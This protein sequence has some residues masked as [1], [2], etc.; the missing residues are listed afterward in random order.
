[1][2]RDL[3]H[4][5]NEAVNTGGF[6][7][8][9]PR[10]G[11]GSPVRASSTDAG[12]MTSFEQAVEAKGHL[13]GSGV[14]SQILDRIIEQ[15]CSF[16]IEKFEV[17]KTNVDESVARIKIQSPD[18]ESLRELLDLLVPLGCYLAKE[19]D[20]RLAPALGAGRVPDDFYSTTNFRT[21][22][23]HEGEWK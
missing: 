5:Y 16:K 8:R 23:R 10:L 7:H 1:S 12:D 17:G 3:L 21:F 18:Q 6:R 4:Q 9:K 22:V 13:I 11:S 19:E 14:I 20:A 2:S 15:K